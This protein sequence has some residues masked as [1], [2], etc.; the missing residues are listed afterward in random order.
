MP[1]PDDKKPDDKDESKP[2]VSFKTEGE[3]LH[4]VEQRSKKALDKAVAAAAAKA[5]ADVLAGLELDEDENLDE[6][7]TRLASSKKSKSEVDAL[8][9]KATKYEKQLKDAEK[10]INE[11]SGFKDRTIRAEALSSFAVKFRDPE[12]MHV[13]LASKLLIG[14]DGKATAPDGGEVGKWVDSFL[15]GKP[16]LRAGDFKPGAGTSKV[17]AKPDAKT[18]NGQKTTEEGF[19]PGAFAALAMAKF[20]EQT[21]E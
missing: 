8:T 3:F 6:V 9:Q 19:K 12:D 11:L 21:G 16:H 7:K 18:P 4:A 2:A 14:D 10:A 13:H 17:P 1:E 20:N 15:E 5:R